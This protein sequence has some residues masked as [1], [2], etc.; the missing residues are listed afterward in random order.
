MSIW[1]MTLKVSFSFCKV[2]CALRE[3]NRAIEKGALMTFISY[4]E[5]N[6]ARSPD[7][8][9]CWIIMILKCCQTKPKCLKMIKPREA[10]GWTI[11][12][13]QCSNLDANQTANDK[14]WQNNKVLLLAKYI[15]LCTFLSACIQSLQ[16][17]AI[18]PSKIFL[19]KVHI[20]YKKN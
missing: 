9:I 19:P 18:T 6:N 11:R 8:P 14:Y 15:K 5:T 1:M 3:S 17:I 7:H 2:F 4:D 12:G 20:G 13:L 10:R 16:Y